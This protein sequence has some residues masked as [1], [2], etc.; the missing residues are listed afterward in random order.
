MDQRA[1][2]RLACRCA[3]QLLSLDHNNEF[4]V[5]PDRRMTHEDLQRLLR[6][7]EELLDELWRRGEEHK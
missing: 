2:K 4:L 3:Y 1:A 7:W 6:S 5:Q